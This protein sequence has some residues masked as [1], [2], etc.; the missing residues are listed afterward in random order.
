[1]IGRRSIIGRLSFYPFSEFDALKNPNHA[2]YSF[3]EQ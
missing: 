2:A 1:M 3:G